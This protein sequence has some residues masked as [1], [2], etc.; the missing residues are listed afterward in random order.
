MDLELYHALVEL[1]KN[2]QFEEALERLAAELAKREYADYQH[3]IE[4]D[5]T[6]D[7]ADI[8]QTILEFI[9]FWRDSTEIN[10][11]YIEMNEFFGNPEHW[12]CEYFGYAQYPPYEGDISWLADYQTDPSPPITLT[13]M[14]SL[15]AIYQNHDDLSE[16]PS[17]LVHTIELSDWIVTLKFMRLI[18]DA[19][20]TIRHQLD[21]PLLCTA[22]GYDLVYRIL[23]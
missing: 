18:R 15:Q 2:N 10:A 16:F 17:E 12:Y 21:I 9:G 3:S 6:N 8:G 1:V 7:P 5:F 22:H 13:G 14:E 20:Q 4:V 11:V 19:A 23:P